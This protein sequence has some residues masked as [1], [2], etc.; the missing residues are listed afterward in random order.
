MLAGNR[1]GV[2]LTRPG[3]ALTGQHLPHGWTI[4]LAT[5][6]TQTDPKVSSARK[7]SP[8]RS[9]SLAPFLSN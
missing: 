6:H 9:R 5:A 7:T 1:V 4:L 8:I 3:V 2:G